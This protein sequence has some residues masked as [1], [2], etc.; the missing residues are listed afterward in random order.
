MAAQCARA[1]HGGEAQEPGVIAAVACDARLADRL[2]RAA[3]EAGDHDE[4]TARPATR[5]LGG[6]LQHRLVETCLADG[7]LRRVHADGKALNA[8][9]PLRCLGRFRSD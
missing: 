6:I 8:R 5:R 7:E 9:A 3:A 1:L 2:A 4:G